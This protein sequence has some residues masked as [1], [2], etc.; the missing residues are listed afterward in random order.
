MGR[1]CAS[2][3]GFGGS[4]FEHAPR[5]V[6]P[7]GLQRRGYGIGDFDGHVHDARNMPSFRLCGKP[8]KCEVIEAC[9][10]SSMSISVWEKLCPGVWPNKRGRNEATA[11]TRHNRNT[12]IQSSLIAE[13]LPQRSS[14]G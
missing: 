4:R 5:H 11:L 14:L 3:V 13:V 2:A 10:E 7:L 8:P 1:E 9:F 6:P 12:R